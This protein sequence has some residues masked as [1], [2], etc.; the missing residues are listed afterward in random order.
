MLIVSAVYHVLSFSVRYQS[1]IAV[2]RNA[3]L[4]DEAHLPLANGAAGF[5]VEYDPCPWFERAALQR[6]VARASAE[7]DP[8][9]GTVAESGQRAERVRGADR[10]GP[11]IDGA[12]AEVRQ[13]VVL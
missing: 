2:C 1:A 10:I 6:P 8:A 3:A 4:R 13:L 7:R 9:L 11:G 5:Y 12:G